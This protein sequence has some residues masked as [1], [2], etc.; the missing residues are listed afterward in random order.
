MPLQIVAVLLNLTGCAIIQPTYDS[1]GWRAVS[2]SRGLGGYD[3]ARSHFVF[4]KRLVYPAVVGRPEF[5]ELRFRRKDRGPIDSLWWYNPIGVDGRQ[6]HDWHVSRDVFD[7]ASAVVARYRWIEGW[8]SAAEGRRV[9]LQMR[10]DRSA[11]FYDFADEKASE[12][13]RVAKLP[14]KPLYFIALRDS[15]GDHF[16][17]V[18]FRHANDGAIVYD[19]GSGGDF[20]KRHWLDRISLQTSATQGI[21]GLQEQYVYVTPAGRRQLRTYLSR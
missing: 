11:N 4:E 1:S 17:D 16:I 18:C 21:D 3:W 12:R 14:G 8:R 19:T 9:V 6:Q 20:A 10:G 13:W 15:E 7:A 2:L 5:L